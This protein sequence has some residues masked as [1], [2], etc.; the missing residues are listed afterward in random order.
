MTDYSYISLSLRTINSEDQVNALI[1]FGKEITPLFMGNPL[2][3]FVNAEEVYVF[4]TSGN[5]NIVSLWKQSGTETVAATIGID[6][7]CRIK[8]QAVV[9]LLRE[10]VTLPGLKAEE[11][12]EVFGF[13]TVPSP[14]CYPAETTPALHRA[15]RTFTSTASLTDIVSARFSGGDREAAIIIAVDATAVPIEEE[16][17]LVRLRTAPVPDFEVDTKDCRVQPQPQQDSRRSFYTDPKPQSFIEE[18][19]EE[20]VTNP[21]KHKRKSNPLVIIAFI[22]IALAAGWAAVKYLPALIPDSDYSDIES[23]DVTAIA[24]SGTQE[25]NAVITIADTIAI[26][27]DTEAAADSTAITATDSIASAAPAAEPEPAPKAA[28]ANTD[29]EKAD[30]EYLNSS[31]VWNRQSLKSDKYRALFDLFAAGNITE[32]VNAEY[33]AVPGMCTNRDADKAVT[34]LWQSYRTD[35]QHSNVRALKRLSG[36]TEIDMHKLMDDLAKIRSPKPNTNPR[37]KR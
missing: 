16:E 24:L 14:C 15:M 31:K 20:F 30:L 28:P 4:D 2:E 5:Q 27:A 35:T 6:K 17:S 22:L 34:F 23:T 12:F 9:R 1:S 3:M 7:G 33:F 26:P 10:C 11:L 21:G 29:A 13:H 18:D 25:D 19:E 37:P 32:I 36:K 8:P